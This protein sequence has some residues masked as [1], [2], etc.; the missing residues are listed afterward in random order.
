MAG[1]GDKVGPGVEAVVA[2]GVGGEETLG[3]EPWL[4]NLSIF[5]SRLRM[6][7]REFSAPLFRRR[8]SVRWR[9]SRPRSFRPAR[10]EA[11]LSVVTV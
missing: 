8:P 1:S 5:R 10:Y 4:L 7:R 9:S 11:S 2:G 6:G 3:A